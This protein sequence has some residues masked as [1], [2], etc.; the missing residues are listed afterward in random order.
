MSTGLQLLD[1]CCSSVSEFV[2][3]LSTR[4]VSSQCWILIYISAVLIHWHADRTICMFMNRWNAWNRFQHPPII[5]SDRSKAVLL[6]WFL[7]IVHFLLVF[8]YLLIMFMIAWWTSAGKVLTSWLSAC[9]MFSICCL[10]CLCS[11]AVWCLGKDVEFDC[12][13]SW[14][15]PFHLPLVTM[16]ERLEP[17]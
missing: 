13:G 5:Y 4:L 1:F 17:K 11:F 14:S 12:I 6:L 8:E 15:L 2:L 7:L 3:L 16:T 10:D 9:A